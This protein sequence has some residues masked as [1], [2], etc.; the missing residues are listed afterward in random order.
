MRLF[1]WFLLIIGIL[2]LYSCANIVS[3]TGGPKDIAP[4]KVLK[5]I[6]SNLSTD[7]KGS[8]IAIFF[9]EYVQLKDV[10]NQLIISP[11][12]N[13]TP[14]IKIKGKSI[15]VHLN[16]QLKEN[17]TYNINFSNAIS[18]LTENNIIENFQYVFSTGKFIDSL[19]ITG[20][21]MNA[22]NL[23]PEKKILVMIYENTSDSVP[24]KERPLYF[25]KTKEN[26]TFK[27]TNIKNGN[28]KL[29]ALKDENSN[30]LY[31]QPSENIAFPDNLINSQN[32]DSITLRLFENKSSKQRLLKASSEGYGK[33][34]FIFSQPNNP[35][36]INLLNT[37]SKKEW[38]LFENSRNSD[39][40][41]FWYTEPAADSMHFV[42]SDAKGPV[43]TAHVLLDKK[44]TKT[45]NKFQ[46]QLTTNILYSVDLNSNIYL[47]S[48]HPIKDYD[49]KKILLFEDSIIKNNY[50]I[51]KDSSAFRQFIL[52]YP[53]KE[54]A[55]YKLMIPK[56]TFLDIFDLKNDSLTY[57]FSTK[58]IDDYGTLKLKLQV[59][60]SPS[61]CIVQLLDEKE[62]VVRENFTKG[63]ETIQY[64][65]LEP[66]K[67]KLKLILDSNG[68][69]RW[70]TGNYL[71]KRQP[72]K[73]LY[74]TEA[75][76]VR[77]NWDVEIEWKIKP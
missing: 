76:T 72:E 62:N 58:G 23:A 6:P 3:P 53:W 46:L 15:Q 29:F 26:G 57:N 56:G 68:N 32:Q 30:Y 54:N 61:N 35:L 65:Y 27:I 55:K 67:Y 4:P 49:S 52:Q 7:F 17:T 20:K 39:T 31:D 75:I 48:S 73:T 40:L 1:F 22:K 2:Q 69:K 66:K 10:E 25:S 28:F 33:I 50:T 5:T 24:Y 45:R 12:L 8:D 21:V 60:L 11:P 37:T 70:D 19:Y 74:Y 13:K 47:K 71:Q 77:A 44:G 43:D 63:D 9:N 14:E 41:I 42:L 59:P 36:S 64:N 51:S 38:A 34:S 18:D 16:E